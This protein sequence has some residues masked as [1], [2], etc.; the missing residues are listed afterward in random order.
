MYADW[1]GLIIIIIISNYYCRLLIKNIM[2]EN[3]LGFLKN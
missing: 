2:I 1:G 3:N